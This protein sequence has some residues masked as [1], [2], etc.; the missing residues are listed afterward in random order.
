MTQR[1]WTTPT[2]ILITT[3]L[4]GY[5]VFSFLSGDDCAGLYLSDR[6]PAESL[7][8]TIQCLTGYFR[9]GAV[10]RR[11][12]VKYFQISDY[13][14]LRSSYPGNPSLFVRSLYAVA[15]ASKL[16]EEWPE[17]TVSIGITQK[18][19]GFARW[20]MMLPPYIGSRNRASK[21]A[22]I[23]MLETG[24]HELSLDHL[25]P[26]LALASGNS[27]FVAEALIQDPSKTDRSSVVEFVGIR[28]ILRNLDRPGIV[29]LVPPQQP[30]IREPDLNSWKVVQQAP[31]DGIPANLFNQTS[32]H[33]SFTDFELPIAMATGAF[34]PEV[35]L[36]EALISAHEGRQWIADLDVLSSF[37]SNLDPGFTIQAECEKDCGPFVILG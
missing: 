7:R 18:P 23:A 13:E 10:D 29:M 8:I 22:C 3:G 28:R 1:C 27:I 11:K 31:F 16:Y 4:G 24:V 12:L 35:T 25:E 9:S 2:S 30:R 36:L 32:L 15:M 5:A 6:A 33:L 37:D 20:A 26:V 17:A 19:I 14:D 21:F 34:D